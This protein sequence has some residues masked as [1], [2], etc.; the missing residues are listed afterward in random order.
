MTKIGLD[1]PKGFVAKSLKDAIKIKNSL[2]FP[3]IIGPSFTLGGSAVVQP[4][5]QKNLLTLL[6]KVLTYHLLMKF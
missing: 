5:I 4:I 2:S 3:I 1:T 6:G